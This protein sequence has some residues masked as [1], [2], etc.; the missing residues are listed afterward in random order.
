LAV[1][2]GVVEILQKMW[3]FAEDRQTIE[4]LNNNLHLDRDCL[5]FIDWNGREN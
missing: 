4:E 1:N 2:W 5:G 3:D